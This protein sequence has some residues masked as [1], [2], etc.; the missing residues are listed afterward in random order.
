MPAPTQG[1]VRLERALI[2]VHRAGRA[3]G[4]EGRRHAV[5]ASSGPGAER[6]ASAGSAPPGEPG[7]PGERE[8]AAQGAPPAG[9][10]QADIQVAPQAPAPRTE[11]DV[12]PAAQIPPANGLAEIVE[13]LKMI[14]ERLAA[15]QGLPHPTAATPA[16][17]AEWV[18]MRHWQEIPF[19]EFLKLRRAGRI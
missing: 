15:L 8:A 16:L 17:F 7:V 18:R 3:R 6:S 1:R 13:R 14:E 10:A 11:P 2:R 12:A 5:P 9:S 19:A 4:P